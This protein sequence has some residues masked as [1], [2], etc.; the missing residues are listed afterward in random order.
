MPDSVII[1]I[2]DR[3]LSLAPP[4]PK[5]RSSEVGQTF[6]YSLEIL[7]TIKLVTTAFTTKEIPRLVGI[8]IFPQLV[9]YEKGST[10]SMYAEPFVANQIAKTVNVKSDQ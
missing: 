3:S 1:K 8:N 4:T 10:D 6:Q 9:K 2:M 7:S 5:F